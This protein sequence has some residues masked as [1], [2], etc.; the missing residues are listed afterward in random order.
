MFAPP[1]PALCALLGRGSCC[2]QV[3]RCRWGS[4]CRSSQRLRAQ[5]YSRFLLGASSGPAEVPR[6][7]PSVLVPGEEGR[8]R[9]G[10]Q[11]WLLKRSCRPVPAGAGKGTCLPQGGGCRQCRS[12]LGQHCQLQ[13]G[14][15]LRL[16]SA[17]PGQ[18]TFP[19]PSPA[20]PRHAPSSPV[21]LQAAAPASLLPVHLPPLTS[22]LAPT[23]RV[24]PLPPSSRGGRF[25]PLC[26]AAR[27]SRAAG[28]GALAAA[29]LRQVQQPRR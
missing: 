25:Q 7:P 23:A 22:P 1:K 12:C 17:S 16:I 20:S 15:L 8:I 29:L 28:A 4:V 11:C 27:A 26:K 2:S 18:C 5:C 19:T 6:V 21:S 24:S 9:P 3:L 14:L 10:G 13:T